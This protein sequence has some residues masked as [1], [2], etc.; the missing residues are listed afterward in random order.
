MAALSHPHL[1]ARLYEGVNDEAAWHEALEGFAACLQCDAVSIMQLHNDT[2]LLTVKETHGYGAAHLETH[3]Q[4]HSASACAIEA[5]RRCC[6]VCQMKSGTDPAFYPQ[7]ST[8]EIDVQFTSHGVKLRW[9]PLFASRRTTHVL[10]LVE[11]QHRSRNPVASCEL[12]ELLRPLPRA[13]RLRARLRSLIR[14]SCL[15]QKIIDRF[16]VPVIVVNQA[17]RP[18]YANESGRSWLHGH[19]ADEKDAALNGNSHKDNHARHL[20]GFIKD[21]CDGSDGSPGS[22][23]IS[24]HGEHPGSLVIGIPLP[25]HMTDD[26]GAPLV[27]LVAHQRCAQQASWIPL[28]ASAFSLSAAE[29]RLLEQ[30]V[31][32]DTLDHAAD[33]LGISKE[34]TRTHLKSIFAKT[35]TKR[36][37][38]LI[39]MVSNI[40]QIH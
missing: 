30:M 10:V 39:R 24:G 32:V 33:N 22:L 6:S 34:T 27:L 11:D 29:Q 15:G 14:S 26:E 38:G 18:V 17:A 25:A 13:V 1:V 3:L 36:Q 31:Q 37:T 28:V 21:L 40:A 16:N 2:Q 23:L 9:F 20:E 7:C 12:A 4:E 5:A 8:S 19:T 35:G